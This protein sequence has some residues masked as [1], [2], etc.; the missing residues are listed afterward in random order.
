MS[1]SSLGARGFCASVTT[2][3]NPLIPL[4]SRSMSVPNATLWAGLVCIVVSG[5]GARSDVYCPLGECSNAGGAGGSFG[6][7]LGGGDVSPPD[8][9]ETI[10]PPDFMPPPPTTERPP[11]EDLPVSVR[12]DSFCP[13][14]PVAKG[15]IVIESARDLERLR[16]CTEIDGDLT[17]SAF[18]AP[19]LFPLNALQH[20][21]GTLRLAMAAPLDGLESLQQ[22][23]GLT[24]DRLQAPS[25]VPLGNLWR[26]GRFEGDDGVL[27]ILSSTGFADLAGLWSIRDVSH[28]RIEDNPELVSLRG[29]T[30]PNNLQELEVRANASLTDLGDSS[31]LRKAE[32]IFIDANPVR[33]L[34]G[35]S[36]LEEVGIL[37]LE[38]LGIESLDDLQALHTA[39][40]VSIRDNDELLD[41]AR[42]ANVTF[43]SLALSRNGRIQSLPEF[44]LQTELQQVQIRDNAALAT[45][46]RFPNVVSASRIMVSRNPSLTRIDGFPQLVTVRTLEVR[47]NQSLL[48]L[49]LGS[50]GQYDV[51]RIVCN[52]ALA[53]STIVPNL[54]AIG[55]RLEMRGNLGSSEPCN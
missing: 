1:F 32:R 43:F 24:L 54:S 18:V 41:I 50:L 29:L 10:N 13:N 21:R 14:Q 48:A 3:E 37:T 34:A 39:T 55:D 42:L 35:L 2:G 33:S 4:E 44:G 5:C 25:L 17:L 26:I 51:A 40:D 52:A 49:E 19:D 45:G 15:P 11:D 46:P 9:G 16:G 20:V 28:V 12:D 27:A 38:K 22:V 30:L 47:E 8:P 7:G 36:T 23:W 6:G 31:N 53:E